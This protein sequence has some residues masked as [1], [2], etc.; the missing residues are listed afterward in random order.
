MQ[1][2]YAT[3]DELIQEASGRWL[4]IFQEVSASLRPAVARLAKH[5]KSAHV[6]CPVHKGKDGNGFR[7]FE[8][9]DDTGVGICN[10]CG[11]RAGIS[12]IA[13][14][15]GWE[16]LEAK[17]AVADLLGLLPDSSGFQLPPTRIIEIAKAPLLTPQEA[18]K[19]RQRLIAMWRQSLEVTHSS[20]EPLR[21]YLA[22]RGLRIG[23]MNPCT[24]RY[25]PN[26]P[27]YQDGKVLGRFPAL[28]ALFTNLRGEGVTL[29][30]TYLTPS[31]RKVDFDP[32]RKVCVY[33]ELKHSLT[34]SAVKLSR[35]G[36]VL[37]V[38]EGL[39][40]MLS[41]LEATRMPTWAATSTAL[42]EA[43]E[44]PDITQEVWIWEDKDRSEAGQEA[45]RHLCER[46]WS[47][48]KR[49]RIITPP[50]NIPIG[51]KSL[52]WNDIFRMSGTAGFPKVD[53][54]VRLQPV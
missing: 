53:P 33:D 44:I 17:D 31:G 26:L 40:T 43:L 50:G 46:V 19:R 4:D 18:A 30:R 27:Y 35:P 16:F 25:H 49:A 8:D 15:E 51:Q 38:G 22:R 6:A 36:V 24:F 32:S 13:W 39:E 23:L 48:G 45:S 28:L 21:L 11:T 10:T 20:A 34:G 5:P 7:L 9:A 52:D 41:V 29:H 3:T 42:L 2:K 37:S 12:L 47:E 1:S 14:A 54:R